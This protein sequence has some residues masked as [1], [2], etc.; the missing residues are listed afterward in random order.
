[1]TT[2]HRWTKQEDSDLLGM[3][4][5]ETGEPRW[6]YIAELMEQRGSVKSAKQCRE[7]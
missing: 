2:R 3:I 5:A 4:S 1:M 7:R 6:D